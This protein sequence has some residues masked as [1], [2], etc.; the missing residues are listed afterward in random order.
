MSPLRD[1][2][3]RRLLSLAVLSVLLFAALASRFTVA[4][5]GVLAVELLFAASVVFLLWRTQP[6]VAFTLALLLAPLSGNWDGVGLPG[7]LSPNRIVL[8]VAVVAVVMRAPPSRLRPRFRMHLM[9]VAMLGAGLYVVISAAASGTLLNTAS[10]AGLVERFGLLPFAACVVA[11][12]VYR[13]QRDRSILV[14]ALVGLGLYLGLTALFET[15]GLRSLVFPSYINNPDFGILYDRARGPFVEPAQNA[16]AMFTC[17]GAA[18]IAFGT[19]RGKAV[20]ALAVVV[21]LLCTAGILFTLTR[22]AWLAAISGIAVTLVVAPRLRPYAAPLAASAAILVAVSLAAIPGF[23]QRASDRR[24]TET[25][26]YDRYALNRA[27]LNM[28]EAHPMFGFGWGTYFDN[29]VDYLQQGDEY[30]LPTNI[31][32]VPTHNLYLGF[33]AELGLVGTS[34]WLL[35]ALLAVGGA[36]VRKGVAEIQPWRW[37][38]LAVA[39]FYLGISSFEPTTAFSTFLIFF[40]AGV[41]N[42]GS[43]GWA[44]ERPER[45]PAGPPGRGEL[46]SAAQAA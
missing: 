19:W 2:A 44:F 1:P 28:I 13:T 17:A 11:P 7:I 23:S 34:L 29:N 15:V 22:A 32:N 10:S 12:A 35:A 40:L 14:V 4:T 45:R 8:A 41:V 33:G 42:G 3:N 43:P 21:V 9:H 30:P 31:E 26:V 25:T 20:R 38:L 5:V 37:L 39:V 18:L 6:V 27:A 46:K 16:L 36:I 24:S